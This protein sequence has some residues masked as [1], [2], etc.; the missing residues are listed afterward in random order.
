MYK[1]KRPQFDDIEDDVK[2]SD[3]CCNNCWRNISEPVIRG[4]F[5]HEGIGMSFGCLRIEPIAFRKIYKRLTKK[6]YDCNHEFRQVP[7][8]TQAVK[9]VKCGVPIRHGIFELDLVGITNAFCFDCNKNF[10]NIQTHQKK[11]KGEGFEFKILPKKTLSNK[12]GSS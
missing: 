12:G 11:H 10:K 1:A 2:Y 3:L 7:E 5:V 9:C 4:I 8:L 6:R